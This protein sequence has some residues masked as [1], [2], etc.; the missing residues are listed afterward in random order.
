MLQ[1]IVTVWN[2]ALCTE[3][4]IYWYMSKFIMEYIYLDGGKYGKI[5]DITDIGI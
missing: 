4:G 5:V 1:Q 3:N 2:R